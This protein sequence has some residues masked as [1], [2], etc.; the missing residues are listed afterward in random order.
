MRPL[1]VLAATTLFASLSA[2]DLQ[3]DADA[4][5]PQQMTAKELLRSCASSSLTSV[6]R[7]RQRY[8]HGFVSGVEEAIRL[9][10]LRQ[11]GQSVG[12]ACAP[13]ETTARQF[14]EAYVRY[15]SRRAVDLEEPAA[16]VVAAALEAAYPCP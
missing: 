7:Q 6:G 1:L 13:P 4:V 15:A 10:A 3:A 2:P 5:F 16:M 11:G 12:R 9:S 14:G 8:C